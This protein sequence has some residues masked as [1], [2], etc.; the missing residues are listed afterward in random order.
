MSRFLCRQL[1]VAGLVLSLCGLP[2]Q[3]SPVINEYDTHSQPQ[4]VVSTDGSL[5]EIVYALGLGAYLVG[6]DTTSTYP[7]AVTELPQIGYKRAL[8]VEGVMSLMPD[9]VL[10]TDDSGPPIVIEQLQQVGITIQ[11]YSASPDLSVIKDKII[12]VANELGV[13][14][15][16]E[17]LWAKVSSQIESAISRPLPDKPVKVL[18]VLSFSDRSPMVAGSDTSANMM[19]NLAGGVNAASTLMGYKPIS[20]EALIG[21]EPDVILMMDGRNPTVSAGMLFS[22]PGFDQI[23]ASVEKRLITMDGMMLLGLGP[24]TGLAISQLNQALYPSQSLASVKSERLQ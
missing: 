4:R 13:P 14:K 21:L 7:K 5:T 6:V 20:T 19:I 2:I 18:F 23:P 12:G 15:K 8:S 1:S 17:T 11:N 24:R 16:G 9:V 3:A 22:S 10:T